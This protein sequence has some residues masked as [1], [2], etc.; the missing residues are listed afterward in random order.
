[1]I[2]KLG[3]LGLLLS[4]SLAK[5]Q[6]CT[7]QEEGLCLQGAAADRILMCASGSWQDMPRGVWWCADGVLV[8]DSSQ[9]RIRPLP[10]I[11]TVLETSTASPKGI[12]IVPL[13]RTTVQGIETFVPAKL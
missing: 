13:T 2:S 5:A 12:T 7:P 9:S 3:G 1:M 6:Q 11:V 8:A 4:H 10:K